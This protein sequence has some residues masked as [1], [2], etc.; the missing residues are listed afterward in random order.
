MVDQPVVTEQADGT[1]MAFVLGKDGHIYMT[2]RQ[3]G[4]TWSPLTDLGGNF[5]AAPTVVRNSKGVVQ[6]DAF[7]RDGKLWYLNQRTA[8]SE[9]FIPWRTQDA[10]SSVPAGYEKQTFAGASQA[11]VVDG[12]SDRAFVL[13][14]DKQGR[15][16]VN[17]ADDKRDGWWV[18]GV[19]DTTGLIGTPSAVRGADG[20]M[21]AFARTKDG[22]IW[23]AK[24]SSRTSGGKT[25]NGFYGEGTVIP[26]IKT[27]GSPVAVVNKD[28]A[29]G[30]LVRDDKG[31]IR[32]SAQRPDGSFG[33]WA[34]VWS[35]KAATDPS[36]VQLADG[37]WGVFFLDTEGV[38]RM[39]WLTPANGSAA[40]AAPN[41]RMKRSTTP[42]SAPES[43]FTG[44][45]TAKSGTK[46]TA[47][48][49]K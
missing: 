29:L 3:P 42:E 38:E 45:P 40:M 36:V 22:E 10:Y 30:V 6:V 2:K 15:L 49:A 8:S 24:E 9:D 35:G 28:K 17:R 13:G 12:E 20:K 43:L 1:P 18:W 16:G 23:A 4:S 41:T 11:A 14:I 5:V 26:G 39:Y 7:D 33:N 31:Y 27:E 46:P 25:L 21:V 19:S 37:R 47:P 32:Y 34:M 48:A 44:G